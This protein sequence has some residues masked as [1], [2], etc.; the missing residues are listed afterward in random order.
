MESEEFYDSLEDSEYDSL[1]KT[2]PEDLG[3][4]TE[5]DISLEDDLIPFYDKQLTKSQVD[6]CKKVSKT[7]TLVNKGSS[8][9]KAK[10]RKKNS[11]VTLNRE[12]MNSKSYLDLFYA[13]TG[14]E[15]IV[16]SRAT[17]TDL[18]ARSYASCENGEEF[19]SVYFRNDNKSESRYN[20]IFV[21]FLLAFCKIFFLVML[22]LPKIWLFL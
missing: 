12:K 2:F 20:I 21:I 6:L 18:S 4:N 8:G 7:S 1:E 3:N 22:L 10:H 5:I 14:C 19:Q 15:N 11:L 9:R 16:S 17:Y 13:R